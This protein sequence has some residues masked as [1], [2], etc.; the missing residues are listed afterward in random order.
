[1]TMNSLAT[2]TKPVLQKVILLLVLCVFLPQTLFA[3]A[4]RKYHY[5]GVYFIGET[6]CQSGAGSSPTSATTGVTSGKVYIL[7]DSITVGSA[8]KYRESFKGKGIETFINAAG[9][10]SWN[11]PGVAGNGVTPEGSA[12]AA[13]DAV[14]DDAGQIAQASGII[15]ALGS[16][17]GVGSNPIEEVISTIRGLNTTNAPIYWVNTAGTNGWPADLSYLGPFNAELDSKSTT[18][19]FSV[20]PWFK[21]V[22]PTG[23]SHVSPT[24]DP[25]G[26]LADGLHPNEKGKGTLVDLVTSLVTG[27]AAAPSTTPLNA[28]SC[29]PTGNSGSNGLQATATKDM[30]EFI[31]KYGQA[32]FNVGKQYGIPYEAILAQ[33]ALESGYGASKLTQQGYNFFG[34]KAG[35]SWNGPTI[36]LPTKE[37][38][39]N[40]KEHTE[41]ASFR[42][43]ATPEEGF[44][45][46]GEFITKNSRYSNALNYPGNPVQY[47]TEIKNAGYATDVNYVSKLSTLIGSVEAY[48][49]EKDLFPPSSEV[50]FDVEPPNASAS[51]VASSPSCAAPETEEGGTPEGN[52]L[53]GKKLAEQKGWTGPEWVC[54]EKLWQKESGWN[55]LAINDAEKN[56]DLNGNRLLD[57]GE[58]MTET[59]D[60][61]YG[62]PQAKPGGKMKEAGGD[63]QTA[64]R[65][66]ILWGL[67]YIQTIY[68]TPC[69]A[70]SHS[71]STGW[72]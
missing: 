61:A 37:Q 44:R 63:W 25:D 42:S 47:I 64:A 18:Q 71:E 6:E 9:S 1:M 54:L 72:Y 10:R 12:K 59:E 52:K 62:I 5:Y 41:M 2:Y 34:M 58:T 45:G 31:D 57:N 29:C 20:I 13:K 49:K 67:G 15:V 36:E 56:N 60:D 22:N 70:W 53:I 28:A 4:D 48:V 66:Q 55:Q 32:A 46:Y 30:N 68:T 35:D 27:S 16:N 26:L 3:Q 33:A 8:D 23:D 39:E 17:G 19:N 69:G 11:G 7:G 51:P 14:K 21:R 38:D 24:Q 40:G 50:E 43:Y 65:T